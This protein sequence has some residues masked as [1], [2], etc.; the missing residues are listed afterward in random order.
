MLQYTPFHGSAGMV[1]MGLGGGLTGGTRRGRFLQ[2]DLL[3][4][5]HEE[6]KY[7]APSATAELQLGFFATKSLGFVAA[8]FSK[9]N[10]EQ[11]QSGFPVWHSLAST[12]TNRRGA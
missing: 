3:I 8:F 12:M 7:L 4:A 1:S 10:K 5:E 2:Y 6:V 9:F 11:N